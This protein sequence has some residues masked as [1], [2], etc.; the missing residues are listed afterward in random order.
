MF[1][2]NLTIGRKIVILVCVGII[3]IVFVGLLGI[4]CTQQINSQLDQLYQNKY[5]HS[6]MA[7][8][9]YSEMLTYAIGAYQMAMEPDNT[10][11]RNIIHTQMDP[12]VT[13]YNSILA[14]YKSIKMSEEE[15]QIYDDLLQFSSEYFTA[16][17][18]TNELRLEGKDEEANAYFPQVAIPARIKTYEKLQDLLVLNN[19]SSYQYYIDAQAMFNS[20]ILTTLI[21]TTICSLLLLLISWIIIRNLT[22]RFNFLLNG[23]KEVG[24]GNLSYRINLTGNDEITH[25]GASFDSMATNL[26]EETYKINQNLQRSKQTN[27][28]IMR[29]AE[30][31]KKGKLDT[32]IK[33]DNFEGEFLITV[34]S[35]N[36]LLDAITVPVNETLRIAERYARVDFSARFD[37]S[38]RVEGGLFTLKERINQIGIHVGTELGTAIREVTTE[39]NSLITSSEEASSRIEEVT[40]GSVEIARSSRIVSK[41]ADSSLKSVEQVLKAMD[42]LNT[43]VFTIVSKVNDVNSLSHE[44]NCTSSDGIKQ[45]AA[46]DSGIRSINNAVTNVESI[47]KDI[48]KQMDEIG[49]IVEIIGGIADQTNLLALNAAIEAARAGDAGKGFAVVANEVKSLAQESQSSSD[50]IAQIISSLKKQSDQAV[51]SMNHATTEVEKGSKAI[52][53]TIIFFHTIAGQVEEISSHMTGIRV[54]SNEEAAAVEEITASITELKGLSEETVNEAVGTA[55]ESEKSSIAIKQ[56]SDIVENLSFITTKINQ[57]M[58]RLN[59]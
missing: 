39:V 19:Q 54:L 56:V 24:K 13:S 2:D 4:S 14:D 29:M 41:N 1:I 30:D 49:K 37:E 53:D 52:T 42:N 46:A 18:K 36:E 11:K 7:Y 20:L 8:N 16:A 32:K 48:K 33:T 38:L 17:Q 15:Q 21:I 50:N 22:R 35:V 25:I 12:K 6:M 23:M 9:A 5:S 28:A 51:Y 47:I 55:S 59:A 58:S 3:V 27:A 10:K 44:A 26:E 57:C 34:Q 31:I 45:A 40:E 43:S